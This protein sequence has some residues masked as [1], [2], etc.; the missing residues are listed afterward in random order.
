M[1]DSPD[2]KA[3]GARG[4][5]HGVRNEASSLVLLLCISRIYTVDMLSS[6]NIKDFQLNNL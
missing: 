2:R 4:H 1:L 6:W 3:R 5:T